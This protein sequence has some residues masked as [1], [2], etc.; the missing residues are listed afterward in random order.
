MFT[1]L[2]NI[3]SNGTEYGATFENTESSLIAH[4]I[5]PSGESVNI[6][7]QQTE[8]NIPDLPIILESET[9]NYLI[10]VSE[11]NGLSIYDYN[12]DDYI[13]MIFSVD[14]TQEL[15]QAIRTP[16]FVT[17]LTNFN[18]VKIGSEYHLILNIVSNEPSQQVGLIYK[19]TD[20]INWEKVLGGIMRP[21]YAN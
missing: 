6:E 14:D 20:L 12:N 17:S 15:L 8:G 16:L 2:K 11:V 5:F 13:Q 7:Q 10:R 4:I 1:L 21:N 19:S 9:E 3:S 18:F